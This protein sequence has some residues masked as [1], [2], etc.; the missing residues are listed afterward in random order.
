MSAE[1]RYIAQKPGLRFGD[2]QLE[3]GEPVPLEPGRNYRGMLDR[4]E[5]AEVPQTLIGD[6][7]IDASTVATNLHVLLA[8][9]EHVPEGWV[10]LRSVSDWLELEALA[11]AAGLEPPVGSVESLRVEV[12]ASALPQLLA[13]YLANLSDAEFWA[14]AQTRG[15][16]GMERGGAAEEGEPTKLTDA[17]STSVAPPAA[18]TVVVAEL[19]AG[20]GTTITIPTTLPETRAELAALCDSLHLEVKGT[21]S[22]GFQK[23]SDFVAALET[24]R[25][26]RAAH[27]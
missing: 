16:G 8:D 19:P 25:A 23:E 1:P 5:I 18:E 26:R 12:D 6:G 9:P 13:D 27:A 24:E 10:H 21:G 20:A 7:T 17:A 11:R 14:I 22:R 2:R 4:G 15:F 3:V